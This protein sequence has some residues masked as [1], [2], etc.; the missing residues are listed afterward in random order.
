[1][2]PTWTWIEIVWTLANVCGMLANVRLAR[3]D[4]LKWLA[5]QATGAVKGGPRH[6][7][8]NKHARNTT[9]RLGCHLIGTALGV[10]ALLVGPGDPLLEV[11]SS[12][13]LVAIMAILA[14][15]AIL[16]LLDDRRLDRVL[17][18]RQELG[19]DRGGPGGRV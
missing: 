4:H 3:T 16:D 14:I 8:A 2:T 18:R 17:A 15:L 13:G 10:H 6:I 7:L 9:G 5:A 12:W 1:M 19:V 11:L